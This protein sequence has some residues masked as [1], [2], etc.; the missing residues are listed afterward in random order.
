MADCKRIIITHISA[1]DWAA[2]HPES[3]LNSANESDFVQYIG[4]LAERYDGDGH[5]DAPGSP[6]VHFYEIY[7]EP[8]GSANTK[9]LERWGE[10]PAD[11]ARVL[12]KAYDA[13]KT[14]SPQAK[15]LFGGV[16]FDCFQEDGG[17]FVRSFV[18]DVLAIDKGK[19]FD[20]FNYHAYPAYS[21]AWIQE[22]NPACVSSNSCEGPGLLEKH[23][24]LL[25]ILR[26]HGAGD[27]PVIITESGWWSNCSAAYPARRKSRP[28][29]SQNSSCRARPPVSR[30]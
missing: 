24:Y 6:V 9:G 28:A 17:H 21:E 4:A 20:I 8:D 1:P 29:M 10:Y 12:A 15:V 25:D 7:N 22:S 26:R 5:N 2:E 30:R 23:E 27:K 11:Y 16:A 19:H 14:A 13:I 18:N 3:V